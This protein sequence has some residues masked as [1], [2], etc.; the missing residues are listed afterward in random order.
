[1]KKTS[2]PDFEQQKIKETIFESQFQPKPEANCNWIKGTTLKTIIAE[3]S[4]HSYIKNI[5]PKI[6]PSTLMETVLKC[7][8]KYLLPIKGI[9]LHYS[10][11]EHYVWKNWDI[12]LGFISNET[13]WHQDKFGQWAWNLL[14]CGTKTWW[15]VPENLTARFET[16]LQEQVVHK[17]ESIRYSGISLTSADLENFQKL[18]E[19][20]MITE[21]IQVKRQEAGDLFIV[22]PKIWHAVRVVT[23]L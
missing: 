18:T 21:K 8:P 7:L 2:L 3:S 4:M 17:P 5:P 1:M 12:Y 19:S 11:P 6:F 15:I 9:D 13:D 10:V 23:K 20:E 22:P 14:L 16:F